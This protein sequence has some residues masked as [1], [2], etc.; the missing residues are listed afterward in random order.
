MSALKDKVV[1]GVLSLA[2]GDAFGAPYEGGFLERG[3]WA[4][5]G[6]KKGK[7]RWTDDTQM[8]LD[9]ME[10]LIA[11]GNVDQE[12]LAQRF[13]Q[14]YRWSRGYGPGAAR[15]LKAV[16]KGRDWE[17]VVCSIY[18]NGS[19]GNGGAMRSPMIGLYY[20]ENEKKLIQAAD[21]V[22]SVTHA[23]P[24]GR[25]GAVLI[26]LATAW[27]FTD[28]NTDEIL[29]RLE[30][31][32]E[33]N[34]FRSRFAIAGELLRMVELPP[35]RQVALQLGNGVAAVESCVT[36]IFLALSFQNKDFDDLLKYAIQIGGDVDTIAAMAG[37]IWG[38]SHGMTALPQ[39]MLDQLEQKDRI[40]VLAESF[41]D[42][43]CGESLV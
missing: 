4:V 38:A 18:P 31:N 21:A 8:S 34:E 37:A 2:L 14:S 42:A 19:Y 39:S 24:L 25:E 23:H 7:R 13:A 9:V 29:E 27:S 5:V 35:P 20:A 40:T 3:L 11:C 33:S 10:S 17:S 28:T 43:C 36:S 32:V 6:K 1:G 22:A 12:D 15:L 41:A 26:A 16:R 30:E